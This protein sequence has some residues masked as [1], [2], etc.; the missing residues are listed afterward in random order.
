MKPQLK[1]FKVIMT[2][3]GLLIGMVT[4]MAYAAVDININ[5]APPAPQYEPVPR[6]PSGYVWAPGYWRYSGNN[7]EWVRGHT[8]REREGYSWVADHYEDDNRY[9]AGRW[10][11]VKKEKHHGHEKHHHDDDRDE[12]RGHG[13]CPP[14]QAKKGNC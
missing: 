12:E 3:A 13:F 11:R 1:S 2:I 7:Y 5:I 10:E 6:L 9:R 8:I 4:P 14:G